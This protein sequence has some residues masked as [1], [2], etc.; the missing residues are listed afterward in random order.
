METKIFG[1]SGGYT[2]NLV[3]IGRKIMK[4][5]K[6]CAENYPSGANIIKKLNKKAFKNRTIGKKKYRRSYVIPP[7]NKT[8]Y[9]DRE[10]IFSR[11]Y[12]YIL[13]DD[14]CLDANS[15]VWTKGSEL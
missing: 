2:G 11:G 12:Y 3:F 1:A 6:H 8:I 13:V 4:K 15:A 10:A 9:Q 7:M 14:R 5:L